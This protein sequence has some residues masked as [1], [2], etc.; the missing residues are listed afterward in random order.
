[1]RLDCFC[2]DKVYWEQ[3]MSDHWFVIALA[4]L[5]NIVLIVNAIHHW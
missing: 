4:V 1:M 3:K 5:A 2:L